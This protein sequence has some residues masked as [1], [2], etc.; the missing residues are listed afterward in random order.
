MNEFFNQLLG[1]HKAAGDAAQTEN[2]AEENRALD[3][4]TGKLTLYHYPSCPFCRRVSAAV[5]QLGMNI[6]AKNILLDAEARAELIA[7]GGRSTVP[8]L[9]IDNP[10]GS[11]WMYESKDIVRYLEGLSERVAGA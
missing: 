1:R 10:D 3:Q 6:A 11:I 5:R 2:E 9:R 8:C 4:A 7:G